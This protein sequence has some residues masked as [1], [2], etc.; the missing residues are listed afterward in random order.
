MCLAAQ[1]LLCLAA[2]VAAESTVCRAGGALAALAGVVAVYRVIRAGQGGEAKGLDCLSFFR[3]ELERRR[4]FESRTW[5]WAV[6]P[7]IPGVALGLGGWIAA[8]PTAEQRLSVFGVAL[9][10]AAM[11]WVIVESGRIE[12]RRLERELALLDARD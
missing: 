4:D 1:T 11:Q 12:Q 3:A 5:S 9:F 2:A 6:A 8:S 10:W 7:F